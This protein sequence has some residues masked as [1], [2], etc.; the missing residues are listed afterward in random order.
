MSS[1]ACKEALGLRFRTHWG[2]QNGHITNPIS[3]RLSR[4]IFKFG[5]PSFGAQPDWWSMD[6]IFDGYNDIAVV[7][8][9]NLYGQGDYTY[10]YQLLEK[11]FMVII[12]CYLLL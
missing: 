4:A 10:R 1:P 7:L 6:A 11:S 12:N 2:R 8:I 3:E 5:T 9:T